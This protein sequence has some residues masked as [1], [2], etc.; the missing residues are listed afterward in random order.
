MKL[1]AKNL[2]KPHHKKPLQTKN[3]KKTMTTPLAVVLILRN[4]LLLPFNII[5]MLFSLLLPIQNPMRVLD[6]P[7]LQKNAKKRFHAQF[8]PSI[9]QKS[10]LNPRQIHWTNCTRKQKNGSIIF[11]K[12]ILLQLFTRSRMKNLPQHY[13]RLKPSL[14]T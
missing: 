8:T 4:N 2:Q 7:K 13:L 10:K 6:Y 11:V 1:N 5:P 14:I 12:R 9:V 3:K